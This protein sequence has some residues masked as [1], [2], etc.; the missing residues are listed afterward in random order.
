MTVL[1]ILLI[2]IVLIILLIG[3]LAILDYNQGCKDT[4]RAYQ[5]RSC[6]KCANWKTMNCPNSSKCFSTTD[7]P[8][9]KIKEE[10]HGKVLDE[11]I[12]IVK[13]GNKKCMR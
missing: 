13:G 9:F 8:Y 4:E 7:K 2:G 10:S 12:E 11:T 6:N 3:M 5:T 1:I